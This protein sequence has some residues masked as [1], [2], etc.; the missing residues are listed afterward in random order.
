MKQFATVTVIGRG[1]AVD[2]H[3][4]KRLDGCWGVMKEV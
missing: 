1:K 4:G 3:P 2:L